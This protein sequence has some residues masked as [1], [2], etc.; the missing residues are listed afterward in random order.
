MPF[1]DLC[2]ALW[3]GCSAT[4]VGRWTSSQT[5]SGHESSSFAPLQL[6]DTPTVA[7]D[8]DDDTTSHHTSE[9]QPAAPPNKRAKPSTP[10]A[11]ATSASPK[12]S[13]TSDELALDMQKAL[14]HLI[15]G[16]IGHTI[17]QCLEKLEFLELDPIDLLRFAAYHIFGGSLNVRE[18]WM[19]LPND[20]E[21]LKG[22]IAMTGTSLGV[23]KDGKIV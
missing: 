4:G 19:N 21:I 12:A 17:P 1:V 2:T 5:T 15:N 13:I 14:R 6:T 20:P 3:E 23:L 18:M 22:W 9:P 16:P 7:L 11:Q 8:D 10:R